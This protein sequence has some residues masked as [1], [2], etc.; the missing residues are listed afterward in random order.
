MK[1]NWSYDS[2]HSVSLETKRECSGHSAWPGKQVV[3]CLDS[4]FHRALY[5]L[6]LSDLR[7]LELFRATHTTSH[8]MTHRMTYRITRV[9]VIWLVNQPLILVLT[10][11]PI[12]SLY[13]LH[14]PVISSKR[15]FEK[16]IDPSNSRL[17]QVISP[18]SSWL[19][20]YSRGYSTGSPLSRFSTFINS[21][22]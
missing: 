11:K 15:L 7:S 1:P 18:S 16:T 17:V 19:I 2:L 5:H 4:N 21:E 3:D 9:S 12:P 22:H 20:W 14:I 6:L 8:H 13:S 10:N